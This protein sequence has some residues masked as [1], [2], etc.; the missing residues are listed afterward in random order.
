MGLQLIGETQEQH[1]KTSMKKNL[2]RQTAI[3]II[4]LLLWSTTLPFAKQCADEIGP[5]STIA[6]AYS[7][8]GLIGICWTAIFQ[9]KN[10]LQWKI[11]GSR[12]FAVRLSMFITYFLLLY[13]AIGIVNLTN[14]P[15][16]ILLNYLWPT[17][18]LMFS[19][20]L[21]PQNYRGKI[22]AFGTTLILTGICVEVLHSQVVAT[23]EAISMQ[24]VPY[25][26]SFLGAVT[27]GLYSA[28]NRKWGTSNGNGE[29]I[30]AIMMG[31]GLFFAILAFFRQETVHLNSQIILPLSYLCVIPFTANVCWDIGTRLGNLNALSLLADLI[32]WI[33]LTVTALYLNVAIGISTWIAAVLIV[34]GAVVSRYSLLVR[35]N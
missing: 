6:I 9:R 10:P 14:Y 19:L 24:P 21:F 5:F 4:A 32:P 33:S 13:S 1:C 28:L 31:I 8:S 26:L 29:E 15:I 11:I 34:F 25:L 2:N 17:F 7:I 22:L 3:G 16:V 30:P 12:R 20:L 27:W 35:Q 18:T 23:S